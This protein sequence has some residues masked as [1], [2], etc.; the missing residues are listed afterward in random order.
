MCKKLDNS[1]CFPFPKRSFLE[2]SIRILK[3]KN[4]ARDIKKSAL[5]K[6]PNLFLNFLPLFVGHL[7]TLKE[8]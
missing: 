6:G 4:L 5:L 1:Y 3:D 2:A 7:Q 8:S